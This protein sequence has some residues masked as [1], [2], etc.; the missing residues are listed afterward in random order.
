MATHYFYTTRGARNRVF[1]PNY[2]QSWTYLGLVRHVLL[3]SFV[4]LKVRGEAVVTGG[5]RRRILRHVSISTWVGRDMGVV[6]QPTLASM[7]RGFIAHAHY[8][9]VPNVPAA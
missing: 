8:G 1:E 2:D 9:C 7:Q 4:A 5:R 6:A 3:A